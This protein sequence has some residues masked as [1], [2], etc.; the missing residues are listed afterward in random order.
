[1]LVNAEVNFDADLDRNRL[2]L[3]ISRLEAVL[4]HSLKSLLIETHAQRT[5]D[6]DTLRIA[7]R[8]HDQ[9]YHADSLVLS[10]PPLPVPIPAPLPLPLEARA[11]WLEEGMPTS[12]M[13]VSGSLIFGMITE[14][15]TGNLGL[16]FRMICGGVI[17]LVSN[18]G[19]LPLETST[20]SRSPPPPPPPIDWLFFGVIGMNGFTSTSVTF[21]G[22][23]AA[24]CTILL[25][26]STLMSAMTTT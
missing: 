22:F 26:R 17:C 5:S 20:I 14:G 6:P 3:E 8:V 7:L 4:T 25:I 13:F 21:T 18:F 1:M 2:A 15:G 9:R 16:S 19:S 12:G 24:L 11:T 10:P 23:G